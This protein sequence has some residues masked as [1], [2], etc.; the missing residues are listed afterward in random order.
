MKK[1]SILTRALIV[2]RITIKNISLP[3]KDIY[4]MKGELMFS[5]ECLRTRISESQLMFRKGCLRTGIPQLH[6]RKHS[7]L[8]MLFFSFPKKADTVSHPVKG[9]KNGNG[10]DFGPNEATIS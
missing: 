6:Y 3:D 8:V 10:F 7:K 4:D 1:V 5:K 2:E 9:V